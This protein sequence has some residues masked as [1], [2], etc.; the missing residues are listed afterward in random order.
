VEALLSLLAGGH[1]EILRRLQAARQLAADAMLFERAGHLHLLWTAL[2]AYTGARSLALLPV[3][4]RNFVVIFKRMIPQTYELFYICHG[5]LAGRLVIGTGVDI[6]QT[7]ET[8]FRRCQTTAAATARDSEVVVDELR[9][10]A[11]WLQR[12][13]RGARCFYLGP[14]V[15]AS[16]ALDAVMHALATGQPPR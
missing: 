5:L 7:I 10:V 4:R 1:A 3:A 14:A 9:L 15:D 13:R 2:E 8:F 6:G 12:S 16:A 11:G